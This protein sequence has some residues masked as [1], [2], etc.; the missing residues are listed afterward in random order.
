MKRGLVL[1]ALGAVV[2][3]LSMNRP[4]QSTSGPGS[5]TTPEAAVYL[6]CLIISNGGNL[7]A[8]VTPS[9]IAAET[10][11]NVSTIKQFKAI[12]ALQGMTFLQLGTVVGAD[13]NL[14]CKQQ[15]TPECPGFGNKKHCHVILQTFSTDTP[16]QCLTTAAAFN[17]VAPT[18]TPLPCSD[19]KCLSDRS[20]G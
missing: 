15:A 10:A 12:T 18:P 8:N 4:A 20:C 16:A 17:P 13:L 1:V 14:Y 3:F 19:P 2:V 5:L 9:V 11:F 7:P 6:A